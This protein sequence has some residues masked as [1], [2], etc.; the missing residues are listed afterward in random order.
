AGQPILYRGTAPLSA[1]S[2]HRPM[3]WRG[4]GGAGTARQPAYAGAEPD[5][6]TERAPA[7]DAQSC[8]RGWTAVSL[9]MP[10]WRVSRARIS[11]TVADRSER[12]S[13]ARSDAA[14]HTRARIVLSV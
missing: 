1:R 2:G 13:R 14:R 6:S 8:Q 11:R 9:R 10:A 12:V 5:R 4:P 7:R 3:G